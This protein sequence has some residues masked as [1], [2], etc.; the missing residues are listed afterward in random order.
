MRRATFATALLFL[1]GTGTAPLAALQETQPQ[2]EQEGATKQE[3]REAGEG[4]RISRPYIPP[5]PERPAP[6]VRTSGATRGPEGEFPE[7]TL[8]VPEHVARAVSDQPIL[9]W[10]VSDET[11]VRIEVTLIDGESVEPLLEIPL[12]SPVAPGIHALRLAEHDIRL[13]AGRTYEWSVAILLDPQ[14]RSADVI[15][16][17]FIERVPPSDQLRVEL[18]GAQGPSKARVYAANG[19]WYDAFS[20]ASGAAAEPGSVAEHADLRQALLEQV[21]L[22]G[23]AGQPLPHVATPPR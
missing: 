8:L 6:A 4:T 20:E 1:T 17:A 22:Q 5:S 18:E 14:R 7:I 10:Y 11:A 9:Y 12:E 19:I 3:A 21:G 16:R 23:L 13:E 15:A 2:Q